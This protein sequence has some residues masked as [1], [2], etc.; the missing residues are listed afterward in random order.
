M[1]TKNLLL[2]L[3]FLVLG[4]TTAFADKY[5]KPGSYKGANT[6]RLTPEQAVKGKK[7]M[8]YNT[9]INGDE[10]RTGFLRNNGSSVELDKTKERDLLV[11][12]E[13]FVY[14]MEG[15]DDNADGV[16]D[17]YAIKSITTGTYI[18]I[19]GNTTHSTAD[20]AK[21][22]IY[23]WDT[24]A[25]NSATRSGVN[26]ESWKYNII[27]NKDITSTGNGS[28]V[29]VVK[30]TAKDDK[31]ADAD[32]Y[33]NGE[34]NSFKSLSNSNGGHPFAF[35]EVFEETTGDY[36]QDLHIYSR[37][38]IY[39][40]QVIYGYVQS[41]AK[42]STSPAT[43]DATANIIDGTFTTSVTT[44]AGTGNHYFQFD[45]GK[46]T[47]SLY[48]YI[49][50]NADKTNVP[51]QVKIEAS[52]DALSWTPIGDTHNTGLADKPSWTSNAID[53]G[54]DYRYIRIVNAVAD[55]QMS[56]SEI[57][58]LPNEPDDKKVKAALAYFA[59]VTD[60][61]CPIYTRATTRVYT[62]TVEEYNNLFPEARLLSG[63]PLPGN[64]YR[65]YADA[66]DI[67]Q[68]VYT[69][70]EIYTDNEATPQ[71]L[72][73]AAG[74]YSTLSDE[75]QKKYEWYCEQTNDGYLVFKN[76]A[77]PTLYLG[78]CGISTTPYKWSISTVL[79]QRHGVPLRNEAQQYLAAYNDGTAWMGDV[80]SVQD[81]TKA[82]SYTVVDDKGDEDETNDETETVTI[83][84]GLCT[85][86]VFIPVEV[87][88]L[89]EKKVTFKANE[90]VKRNT[91]FSYDNDGDGNAEVLD[92]P[93]ARMFLSAA[94]A[95]KMPALTLKC[96]EYHSLDGFYVNGTKMD[97]DKA[98]AT[99]NNG[100]YTF[101]FEKLTDGDVVEIRLNILEPFK[102][103]G[104]QPTEE[105]GLYFIKNR[106][107]QSLPQQARPN[108]ADI[109]IGGDDED[110][111]VSTVTGASYYAKFTRKDEQIGLEVGAPKATSLFYFGETDDEK[112]DEYYNVFIHNAT[113][114]MKCESTN[115]WTTVGE[116]FY[117]QPSFSNTLTGYTITTTPLT[118]NTNN[119]SENA[120]C[121][122]HN[123]QYGKDIVLNYKPTDDGAMW[124]FE[125]VTKSQAT[126]LLKD[127]IVE[128]CDS[129][130]GK[131][132][133][134]K[135]DLVGLDNAKIDNYIKYV[136]DLKNE[137]EDLAE[138]D[139]NVAA[140]VEKAQKIHM[141]EHE[142]TYALQALPLHTATSDRNAGGGYVAPHWYYLKNVKSGDSGTYHYAKYTSDN[143]SMQLD[144]STT[145]TLSNLFFFEGTKETTEVVDNHLTIDEFLK[146]KMHNF[147][148]G[149]KSVISKNN[150]LFNTTSVT[151]GVKTT[152]TNSLNLE[153]T[154]AWSIALEY[155]LTGTAF[156]AY[157][158]SLLASTG[159]P[160]ADN[161]DGNFQ[162]YFKDDRS[163]VVKVNN[164][165]DRYRFWHTQDA[166]SHIKVVVTYALRNVTVDVYNANNE[167]ETIVVTRTTLNDITTLSA[168]LPKEGA[169][170]TNLNVE[171]VEAMKWGEG[172]ADG[173]DNTWYIFPSSNLDYVG[174]A[175]VMQSAHDSN[176]GW[177]N[178]NGDNVEVFTDL[179]SADNSTWQF[180]RVTDF[181]GHVDELLA[182]FNMEGCV[183]YNK[184]LAQFYNLIVRNRDLIKA[185][186]NG[187]EEE[188]LFNELYE[189]YS[190]FKSDP[191]A[192]VPADYKAPKPG[193]LYTIRP[194]IEENTENALLVHVDA[195][196]NGLATLELHNADVVRDDYSYDS[197]AA[198]VFEGADGEATTGLKAK[199]IHTQCYIAAL[200]D[201]E[202]MLAAEGSAITLQTVENYGCTT[203][204]KVGEK[205][206][207]R[208]NGSTTIAYSNNT[209]NFWGSAIVTP[210]AGVSKEVTDNSLGAGK[211]HCKSTGVKV[212]AECDVKVTFTYTDGNHKI[213]ILG[214]E[215]VDQCGSVVKSDYRY[216][217]AGTPPNDIKEYNFN[218]V[219][220]GEYTLNSYV[221]DP[222][223]GDNLTE[224][225]G[226]FVIEGT[227]AFEVS[228]GTKVTN[229]GTETTKW[230]IEEI[231]NPES[232][233]Y[234]S[235]KT[236][237]AGHATLML[238]FPALIPAEV[239]AFRGV[240]H[241]PLANVQYFS[242]TSYGEPGKERI[243]PAETPVVIRNTDVS[244]TE[245]TA[246]F[247]Y[248]ESNAAREADNYLRGSL[249][250]KV[251][252]AK[253]YDDPYDG[254]LEGK[255]VNIYMLQTNKGTSKMYWIYEE[256]ES[257]GTIKD[258][259]KGTDNGGHVLCKANKAYMILPATNTSANSYSLRFFSDEATAVEEIFDTEN[260]NAAET[261][262][263]IYD[264][265]GRRLSE[266]T[267]SGIY[268]VN[269]K[270]VL[271]K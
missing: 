120:W 159:D 56:I 195:A 214:I 30:G 151:T 269:G 100:V 240:K 4:T 234:Y 112:R 193:K 103:Y 104:Q 6:P 168:A 79:T 144:N 53:L 258:G 107:V 141:L 61:D 132:L 239:E 142:L 207:N 149:N 31:G 59:A 27:A 18:D 12:N 246:K 95:T 167:K 178:V 150:Q 220:P 165:D 25:N 123:N 224:T 262:E 192:P 236:S 94:D 42:I 14:T 52:T 45:L 58:I 1:K 202:S 166:Y 244:E 185:Q 26:M 265:Q 196:E 232:K 43:A 44:A 259:N 222:D 209:D 11:Y 124:E 7:F 93:F 146:V 131:V 173:S 238:G 164:A 186:V 179:G 32:M 10:D 116:S 158:S 203:Q 181:D 84:C 231:E 184:K 119:D 245:K 65:I 161:Y 122:N 153:S 75:E 77:N 264:L 242:M 189:A 155:D 267:T 23:S 40:A 157:G 39:S 206:M 191:N 89:V 143:T 110:D 257:D 176:M 33:W 229:T 216:T 118:A 128:L 172:A 41:S 21:L 96:P 270:K 102:I 147:I 125:P 171:S 200:G 134:A 254:A 175:I 271:V 68:G 247:Y 85:D 208:T 233:V 252:N 117:V 83:N 86:F 198:W 8:I 217:S 249:Y 263:T 137:S 37:S 170:L 47:N 22:Y 261:V 197:R 243:L 111:R 108:R 63:V 70:K 148:A 228:G 105:S 49:Q 81:Q 154:D 97:G 121:S 241:G 133:P 82:Y 66:Y 126:T 17:W 136:T 76:V 187:A 71:L 139:A 260:G 35:Y 211:V 106:R 212:E 80:R 88:D 73:E 268:I 28:T 221:Y 99:E 19:L 29:F 145:R 69:N 215:L 230:I 67:T 199:N 60:A 38:D 210:P 237:S 226:K 218:A 87:D 54:A 90:L 130:S 256:Y 251:V 177:T 248:R 201:S 55:T 3:L 46:S 15:H 101:N 57:A 183:I 91:V 205:Y 62:E 92:L 156:N 115:S 160:T 48:I 127:F 225:E 20:A 36:L 138:T 51:T 250:Y 72:M 219:T 213:N 223:T 64:K 152:I 180:E 2:C 113:T 24:A 13:S 188:K 9:A 194:Y 266:I 140:L 74:K 227:A 163:V 50:R 235:V 255:D 114:T 109:N 129:L 98:V 162:V 169:K 182:D 78:N 5:Y 204:F 16:N 135:K 253:E 190:K 34:V 174:H